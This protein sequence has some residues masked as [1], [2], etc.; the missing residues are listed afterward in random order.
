MEGNEKKWAVNYSE[1][2]RPPHRGCCFEHAWLASPAN[3]PQ[4]DKLPEQP[5]LALL[6]LPPPPLPL[7]LL[8]VLSGRTC[9]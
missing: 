9:K 3:G 1:E 5:R 7:G 2:K 6:S 8:S 4:I